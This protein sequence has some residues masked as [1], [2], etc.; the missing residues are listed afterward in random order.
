VLSQVKDL[1]SQKEQDMEHVE[2]AAKDLGIKLEEGDE[3]KIVMIQSLVRGK[4]DR[5]RVCICRRML[6]K[7]ERLPIC[8]P[9]R[10]CALPSRTA[11]KLRNVIG[12]R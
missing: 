10:L 11:A 3:E 2:Q 9:P 4:R 7:R 1:R 6:A 8:S 12:C 5:Q